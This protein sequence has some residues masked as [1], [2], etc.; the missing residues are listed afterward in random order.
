MHTIFINRERTTDYQMTRGIC[1]ILD[2]DG[3]EE[4]LIAFMADRNLPVDDI[5]AQRIAEELMA[6]RPNEGYLTISNA[7]QWRL[8]YRRAIDHAGLVPGILRIG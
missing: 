2:R 3:N 8:Q 4:D 1:E 7:L 6:K 5:E